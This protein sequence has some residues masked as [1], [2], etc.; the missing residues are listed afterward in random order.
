MPIHRIDICFSRLVTSHGCRHINKN[1]LQ[2]QL[3][4]RERGSKGK[5]VEGGEGAWKG[6]G[7][8]FFCYLPCDDPA[9]DCPTM[10]MIQKNN[11]PRRR[12]KG[13]GGRLTVIKR[14][15]IWPGG[16]V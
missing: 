4:R 9:S 10:C 13:S 14:L 5:G 16:L 3:E 11:V 6:D 1:Q 2:K 12:K 7:V 15:A 8:F